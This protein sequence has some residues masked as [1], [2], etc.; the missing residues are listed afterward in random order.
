MADA[1]ASETKRIP[2]S[3]ITIRIARV[4]GNIVRPDSSCAF[5]VV[6]AFQSQRS[7][8]ASNAAVSTWRRTLIAEYRF[9]ATLAAP[10]RKN[11]GHYCSNID[12]CLSILQ[13]T[14][15]VLVTEVS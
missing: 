4:G 5:S 6:E 12:R 9:A 14:N 10:T 7:T 13:C 2:T 11:F 8:S 1:A 15:V 3:G